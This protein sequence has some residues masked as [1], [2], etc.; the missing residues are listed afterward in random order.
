MF[1]EQNAKLA[2]ENSKLKDETKKL[3]DENKSETSRLVDEVDK[4][5]NLMHD[6]TKKAEKAKLQHEVLQLNCKVAAQKATLQVDVVYTKYKLRVRSRR[7]K[8]VDDI[9][10]PVAKKQK[11]HHI[12]KFPK[13]SEVIQYL[14]AKEIKENYKPWLKQKIQAHACGF[15]KD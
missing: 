5:H 7:I 4:A 11:K 13:N 9:S 1:K 8:N 6:I 3:Q 12:L 15:F 10:L 14:E 2:A